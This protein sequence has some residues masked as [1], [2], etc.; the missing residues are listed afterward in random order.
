MA[1]ERLFRNFSPPTLTA[2]EQLWNIWP[3]KVAKAHA[4]IA[5]QR[6]IKKI[7]HATILTAA[8]AYAATRISQNRDYTVHLATWLNGERWA[9]ELPAPPAP[10]DEAIRQAEKRKAMTLPDS[11][12]PAMERALVRNLMA[13]LVAELKRKIGM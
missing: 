11:G 9:D 3:R 13:R 6:A 1:T 12:I 8:Q 5:Y 10:S 7:D 2:F 4:R